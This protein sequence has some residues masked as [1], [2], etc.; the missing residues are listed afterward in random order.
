MGVGLILTSMFKGI[1]NITKEDLF[2]FLVELLIVG[3]VFQYFTR[4]TH[5]PTF[6]PAV[7]G[8]V[9]YSIY[10]NPKVFI[11][12]SVVLSLLLY[13]IL[14]LYDNSNHLNNLPPVLTSPFGIFSMVFPFFISALILENLLIIVVDNFNVIFQLGKV[15]LLMVVLTVFVTFASEL[16]F[17]GITRGGVFT[18]N[19]PN[20]V[21]SMSFGTLYAMPFIFLVIVTYYRINNYGLILISLLFLSMIIRAGYVTALAFIFISTIIGV[22]LRYNIKEKLL[23]FLIVFLIGFFIFS[24]IGSIIQLLPDLPNPVYQE[25]AKEF[26]D[27]QG[28]SSSF[29]DFMSNS[30][31]GVYDETLQN[32]L[33]DPFFG[34]GN[35]DKI[36]QHSF[37]LDKFTLLGGVGVLFYLLL[38]L[39][40]YYGANKLLLNSMKVTYNIVFILVLVFLFINP[41]EWPDFWLIIFVII[42][43]IIIFLSFTKMNK[44]ENDTM[45]TIFKQH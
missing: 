29:S 21:W 22:T 17:P 25:K 36:G 9:L 4:L 6:Y 8:L 27:L 40:L 34:I 3:Q 24:N 39:S 37:W 32:I 16:F 7:I 41:I 26:T 23:V 15:S 1:I 38:I 44:F 43:S 11:K 33:I 45:I 18:A 13:L 12:P 5:I 10:L 31:H 20:W 19:Y 35:Y 2:L 14:V 30:R 42:P 28:N